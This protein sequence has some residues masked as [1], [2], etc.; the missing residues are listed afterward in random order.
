MSPRSL[1]PNADEQRTPVYH[2]FLLRLWCEGDNPVWHASL[3]STDTNVRL[4]FADLEQLV[5]YLQGLL[6]PP[7]DS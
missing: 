5:A 1:L 4:G 7:N 3:Q 2:A 6:R